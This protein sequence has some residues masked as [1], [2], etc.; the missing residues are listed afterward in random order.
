MPG[1]RTGNVRAGASSARQQ[2]VSNARAGEH[3][4]S[5][6]LPLVARPDRDVSNLKRIPRISKPST[7]PLTA[8]AGGVLLLV[9]AAGGQY[10]G[11]RAL[12]TGCIHIMRGRHGPGVL[13][14]APETAYWVATTWSLML[15]VALAITGWSLVKLARRGRR[16]GEARH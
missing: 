15:G 4:A 13:H 10:L 12:A 2:A 9:L 8:G 6:R 14:C 16:G 11:L 7:D 3:S 5:V 1:W